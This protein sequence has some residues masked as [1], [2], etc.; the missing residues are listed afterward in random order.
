M[1]VR[2][3]RE[4]SGL[5]VDWAFLDGVR[6]DE[7]FLDQTLE[8]AMRSPFRLLVRR[9]CPVAEVEQWAAHR[10]RD[11][12]GLVLHL[13]RCGSTLVANALR[14]RA[15]TT[16]LSEPPAL[17]PVLAS[18]PDPVRDVRAL[19]RA[20][21][22]EDAGSAYVLKL[23]A[24]AALDLPVLLA[25]FPDVP[26]VFVGREPAEVVVSH[27]GHRGWHVVPGT[28][29]A[30][31]LGI[32]AATLAGL[33]LDDHAAAVLGRILASAVDGVRA[34]GDRALVVDHAE[35]PDP[36]IP[37]VL[38]HLGLPLTDDDRLAVASTYA[39]HGKNPHLL[40]ADDRAAK[41]AAV[42]PELRRKVDAWA[43]PAYRAL[44]GLAAPS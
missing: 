14:A 18:S 42:T 31:R 21:A 2:V 40:Y 28:L 1:P 39:L 5:V 16:V 24:W 44:R 15:G 33:D 23:D 20:M 7:P 19:V 26:W 10:A 38:A 22:P 29:T 36:G 6:L 3:D 32:D 34:A 41:Q 8:R 27:H 25:A 37:R 17:E 11:P 9:R 35:L 13:S 12:D 4:P 43:T 30:S